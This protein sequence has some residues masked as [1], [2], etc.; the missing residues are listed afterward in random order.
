MKSISPT[1]ARKFFGGSLIGLS[2]ACSACTAVNPAARMGMS[3]STG[4]VQAIYKEPAA[5]LDGTKT[6]KRNWLPGNTPP[7]MAPVPSGNPPQV[8]RDPAFQQI[9]YNQPGGQPGT[10]PSSEFFPTS[11]QCPPPGLVVQP[12]PPDPRWPAAGPNPMAPGMM[13]CDAANICS[14]KSYPDEYLCDGGD[15]DLP[16]HYDSEMRLG[17]DTED[18]VIEFTDRAGKERMKPTNKVCVY[19]PRFSSVR[20]VSGP[21]QGLLTNEIAGVDQ[22]TGMKG[23]HSRLKL[24]HGTKVDATNRMTVRSRVSGLDTETGMDSVV[25]LRGPSIHEKIINLYQTLTFVRTGRLD[26]TESAQLGKGIQA[27]AEWTR[28]QFPVIAAKTDVPIEGHFE[29]S[30]STI[31]AIEERDEAEN[32]RIVKLADK[33]TAVPGD[34]ITFTIRYDNLGGR[35]V[36]YIRIVDN[37]TPRLIYVDDSATSDRAGRLILQ[38]NGEGSQILIWELEE[39]LPGKTGGVV[40]FKARVR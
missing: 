11:A 12:C 36:Y 28:E 5:N 10:G 13:A 14:P 32:L 8:Y 29:Q 35:E 16:V 7:A 4:P 19:A 15:R 33:Q 39:P 26:D 9:N 31:T 2:L 25:H 37:L 17:L 38:D 24:S 34:E 21:Q 3:D 30:V 20:T 1:I 23:L 27:A 18:T 6:A 22:S 40:T